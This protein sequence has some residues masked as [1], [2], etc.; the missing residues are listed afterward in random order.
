MKYSF[1]KLE[2][3]VLAKDFTK[4]IYTITANFP[5]TERFSLQNQ[6]RRASISICSNIAE[7]T[8]RKTAKD[9]ARFSTIAYSSVLEVINQLIL[10]RE[11]GYI[12]DNDYFSARSKI[13][14]ISF[15]LNSL[16]NSQLNRIAP[17]IR[18]NNY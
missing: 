18:Q 7:G 4:L 16:R 12:S 17:K 6:I 9:Q 3:W 2:V 8:G 15:S 13:E 11:L 14:K 1:E 5:I 10:S